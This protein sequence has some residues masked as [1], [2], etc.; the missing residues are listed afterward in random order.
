MDKKCIACGGRLSLI[1]ESAGV[2]IYKCVH[3]GLG[4]TSG[5]GSKKP[6]QYHRDWVYAK[7]EKQ[8]RNI[9]QKRADIIQRFGQKGNVLEIGSSTGILSSLL[10]QQGWDVAG[11]EPSREA[12][13]MANKRGVPTTVLPFERAKLANKKYDVLIFNH[14]LEHMTNPLTILKKARSILGAGGILFIDVPNFASLAARVAGVS[15]K[16]ILPNEHLWHFTPSALFNLL[17]KAGFS[18]LWWEAHSGVWGYANPWREIWESLITGKKRFF[19]NMVTF[20]PTWIL[21]K[22]KVGTGLTVVARKV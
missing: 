21:T 16:Y 3:C 9:F 5:A 20:L 2:E 14:T 4:V 13:S 6:G 12:A 1:G 18:P 7:R 19:W 15:W 17:N 22:L 8:F 11:I 10:K